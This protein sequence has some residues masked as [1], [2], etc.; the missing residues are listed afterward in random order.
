LRRSDVEGQASER[1]NG[2]VEGMTRRR[3][4]EAP[5]CCRGTLPT[6]TG[7]RH[8]EQERVRGRKVKARKERTQ[9]FIERTTEAALS[10]RL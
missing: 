2:A 6:E 7:T 9:T 3:A 10:A 8:N 5:P 4:G 1:T